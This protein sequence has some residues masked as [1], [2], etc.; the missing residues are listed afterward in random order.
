MFRFSLIILALASALALNGCSQCSNPKAEAPAVTAPPAPPAAEASPA[1]A[2]PADP[3]AAAAPGAPPVDGG[4][5]TDAGKPA[6]PSDTTVPA[7][8]PTH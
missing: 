3:N 2:P 4:P 6:A 1:M 5:G 7:A 8:T